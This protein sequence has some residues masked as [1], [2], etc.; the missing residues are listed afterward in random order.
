MDFDLQPVLQ[1]G[2]V[3]LRPVRPEDFE[4]MFEAASDPDIW[5]QHPAYDRYKRTVFQNFFDGG[6]ASGGAFVIEDAATGEVIGSTRY[7][8]L[9]TTVRSVEIGWT[10]LVRSRWGGPWNGAVKRLML[11]HAFGSLDTVVLFAGE[12]NHR[13]R[14]AIEK[15][16]GVEQGYRQDADGGR[17]VRYHVVNPEHASG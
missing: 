1:D 9:D 5:A 2:L 7:N 12:H 13:S 11:D 16:G 10:F 6:L 15:I 4:A 14:R 3:R 8:G 17:S